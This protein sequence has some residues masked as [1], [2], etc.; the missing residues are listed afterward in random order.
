MRKNTCTRAFVSEKIHLLNVTVEYL[1]DV[2]QA[3][4]MLI[5]I[6]NYYGLSR[7][8]AHLCCN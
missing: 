7:T 2:N 1:V 4:R 6:I 5:S 3:P 8:G